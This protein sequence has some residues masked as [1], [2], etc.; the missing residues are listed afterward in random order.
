MYGLCGNTAVVATD[1]ILWV[2]DDWDRFDRF[3]AALIAFILNYAAYFAEIFR[4]GIQSIPQGQYE[5]AQVLQLSPFQTVTKIV[6]PSDKDCFTFC[7]E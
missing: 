1:F 7:R 4:G 6:I 2:A 3:E 5:A